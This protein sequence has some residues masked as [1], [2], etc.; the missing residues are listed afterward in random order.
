MILELTLYIVVFITAFFI[1]IKAA[2][3][4]VDEAAYL[5]NKLGLSKLMIGLTIVAIGTSLPELI[6]SLG[7]IFFT[8]NFSDFLIGTAIGSNITNILLAFG[9]FLIAAKTFTIEKKEVFSVLVLLTTTAIFSV[10]IIQGYVPFLAILFIPLYAFYVFYQSKESKKQII[11]EEELMIEKLKEHPMYHSYGIL[12]LSFIFIFIGA[13]LVVYSIEEGGALVG[14]PAAYLTLT[15]I[16]LATSLP[17]IAVTLSSAKKKEYLIGIGNILGTNIMNVCLIIGLSGLTMGYNIN[18]ETY[19]LS[20]IIFLI[21]TILF[22]AMILRRKF[23][24]S[25]GVIFLVM[26]AIYMLQFLF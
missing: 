14:I 17:E 10:F 8:D 21:A 20:V 4:F 18:S 12:F 25:V 24:Y 1:I 13:K 7:S 16:A 11:K 5:G 9:L 23:Y 15:T 3:Y 22:G 26:Y 2:D 19:L 6:T